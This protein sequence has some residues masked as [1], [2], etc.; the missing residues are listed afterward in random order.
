MSWCIHALAS[1]SYVVLY[2]C[3][4]VCTQKTSIT[5]R[6]E[7][8]VERVLFLDSDTYEQVHVF[9]LEPLES[10]MACACLPLDT[11]NGV[12]EYFVIGT[13]VCI[14]NE[15]E[16]SNGRIV[17]F[18]VSSSAAVPAAP[19]SPGVDMD[20]ESS[21]ITLNNSYSTPEISR[22]I[23][24]VCIHMVKG[25]VFSVVGICHQLAAGVGSKVL[26]LSL[27]VII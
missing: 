24:P 13:A 21:D 25:A 20:Q 5:A 8:S 10:A 23:D 3:D 9:E 27:S 12:S 15:A 7:V 4:I 6:G 26:H 17:V 22:G 1:F 2:C 16:P 11:G 18:E 14:P 19:A